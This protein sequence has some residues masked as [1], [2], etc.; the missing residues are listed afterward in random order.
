[1]VSRIYLETMGLSTAPE[2]LVWKSFEPP[3]SRPRFSIST[4]L[5]KW[6]TPTERVAEDFTSRG[7][8]NLRNMARIIRAAPTALVLPIVSAL[9]ALGALLGVAFAVVAVLQNNVWAGI[10]SASGSQVSWLALC[11]KCATRLYV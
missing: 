3:V 8:S 7:S 9:I 5:Q 4:L 11:S 6:M 1:M 2:T 10:V